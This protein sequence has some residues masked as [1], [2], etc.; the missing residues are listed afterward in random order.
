MNLSQTVRLL[1]NLLGQVLVEQESE[2]IFRIE[3]QIRAFSKQRRA[4]DPHAA[5]QLSKQVAALTTEQARAVASA[6]ALYFDLVNLAEENHRVMNYTAGRREKGTTPDSIRS[7]VSGFKARR[8]TAEQVQAMLDS[9]E[10]ELVLTAHPTQAKRR[11][12]M[13]KLVRISGLLKELT[14]SGAA[15]SHPDDLLDE[16]Y[17]EISTYWLTE[18]ERTDQPEVTDEVR[19]GLYFIDE[20]FWHVLPQIYRELE[21]SLA[22]HYPGVTAPHK[23]LRLASWIGG[24]RDGNPNVTYQIT[25]E[26]LRLHRGLAIERHRKSVQDLARRFTF[27]ARLFPPPGSLTEWFQGRQPLPDHVAYLASR[28]QNEPY[29]LALSLLASDLQS[30]SQEA[31]TT[32]LLADYPHQAHAQLE[33]LTTPV[34]IISRHLP[35]KLG[36]TTIQ[37]LEKQLRIFGL[38][39]ARLDI[40]EDAARIN[41]VV[42]EILRALDLM[43]DFAESCSHDRSQYLSRLLDKPPSNLA[44]RPGVTVETAQTWSVF[45]LIRR[46]QQVYGKDLFGAFVISMTQ[47]PADVLSVLLLSRWA[48]CRETLDIAPLF[49]TVDDLRNA[50]DV[51]RDLFKHPAYRQHLQANGD[52]QMVMIGYSDSN[53][54]AGYLSANWNLYQAQEEIA[55][56][57]RHYGIKLTLFHGRGGTVARGGGPANRA[58]QAQPPGTINGRFRLTEQ[59]ETIASRYS[60]PEIA[61]QHLEQVVSAVLC[62][63]LPQDDKQP[64]PQSWRQEMGAMSEAAQQAYRQLVYHTPGFMQ[65]WHQ[66]TP[67]HEITRLRIG[68][69]PAARKPDRQP[70]AHQVDKIR[71]IPWVFS[72]MQS[73][74]NLPGWFGLGTGL[75]AASSLEVLQEMYAGWPF[76]KAILGNAEMSLQK[77]DLEIARL[78]LTLAED[79]EEAVKFYQIIQDEFVRTRQTILAV[80][81]HADLLENEPGLLRSI[82]LRNPYIDPLNFVQVETLRRLRGLEDLSSPQAEELQNIIVLTINGIAAGLRN[83]G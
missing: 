45:K 82:Q 48:G 39:A 38:H 4:G 13:S 66:V 55:A 77:A 64:V 24:D 71:A 33:A 40:R 6:F 27:S 22:E 53:K 5:A 34:E 63:S 58:I 73:R 68:S 83:T 54:D 49:E 44:D 42:G 50:P 21:D 65:F 1:G 70:G 18:R 62:A 8:V 29:R 19:T 78:Y 46:A 76:F 81:G 20:V 23:W 67:I 30:A 16:L 14:G 69:R 47:C 56:V 41:A 79:R 57:C 32:H 60:N 61:N 51:L 74:F 25:A 11:S 15:S 72:W 37:V 17:T 3:E 12:L 36:K 52:H 75:S 80:S 26:T 2:E 31:M 7:A 59:G 10:I 9:L 43:P 28:Y 35:E